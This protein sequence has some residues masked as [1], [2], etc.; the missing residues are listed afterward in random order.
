MKLFYLHSGKIDSGMANSVQVL[1]MCAA[2]ARLGLEVTLA[3]PDSDNAKALEKYISLQ[4]GE[5]AKFNV[6][7]FRQITICGRLEMMGGYLGVKRLLKTEKMDCC[8]VRNPVFLNAP[9]KYNIP[10]VFESHNSFIHGNKFLDVLWTRNLIHNSQHPKLVKFIGISGALTD[11]WVK[12][13]VP[14]EKGLALHDAVNACQYEVVEDQE[15]LRQAL[16]LPLNQKIV[17]YAGSLYQDRGIERIL[18]LAKIFENVL[19]VV[20]GGPEDRKQIYLDMCRAGNISNIMFTGHVVHQEVSKYLHA[21]DV[22]L[23]IWSKQVPTINYCS[24]LKM[25]EYMAAERIIVGDAFPTILEVLKDGETAYLADPDSFD[26]LRNKLT[27]AL[28]EEYPNVMAKKARALAMNNYTW[29][30]RVRTI[31]PIL[32]ASINYR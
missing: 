12:A 2:F 3:L 17:V 30:E 28:N 19:F 13:G 22:L 27:L 10:T 23:M 21:A 29:D 9:L 26:D 31:L 5:A 16:A 1:Q 8:Y 25:F 20:V 6:V 14:K 24:P 7:T 15:P 11:Y 18:D 32:E 4:L